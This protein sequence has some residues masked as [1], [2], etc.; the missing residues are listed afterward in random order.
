MGEGKHVRFTVESGGVRARAVAFGMPRLPEGC[1]EGLDATFGLELNEWNGAVEPRLVLRDAVAPRP[2]PV[3]LLEAGPLPPEG[4]APD[5]RDVDRRG[6]G[7]AGTL[8]MLAASG[9]RVLALC[10]DAPRWAAALAPRLGGF[11][12]AGWEA[13][14]EAPRFDHVVALEPPPFGLP[15]MPVVLAWGEAE[16]ALALAAHRHRWELRPHVEALYRALRDATELAT[17]RA[18]LAMRVLEELGL[19]EDSRLVPGAP[20]T[21]LERSRTFAESERLLAAGLAALGVRSET[22]AAAFV[23]AV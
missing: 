19:A 23:E 3:E 2:Q 22:A 11:T 17:P 8:G 16:A 15:D 20:R 10:A 12:L 4:R 6:L 18:E 1:E 13:A 5:A 7:V 9:E 21:V 14:A